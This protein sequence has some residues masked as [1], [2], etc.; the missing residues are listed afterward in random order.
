MKVDIQD[1]GRRLSKFHEMILFRIVQEAL[2]NARKH[3]QATQIL[4]SLAIVSDRI[5][6]N[7]EDNGVGFYESSQDKLAV[8]GKFGLIGI[9]ERAKL[10]GGSVDIQSKVGSSTA[11][12][13]DM[14]IHGE[15]KEVGDLP[16]V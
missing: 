13:V 11:I 14:P 15:E 4:L 3:S 10:S 16:Q 2:T 9:R 6:L 8:E 12:V 5:R 7:I 1:R